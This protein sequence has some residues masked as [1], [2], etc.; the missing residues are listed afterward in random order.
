MIVPEVDPIEYA[1]LPSKGLSTETLANRKELLMGRKINDPN[2]FVKGRREK[3]E[4]RDLLAR[5]LEVAPEA[6]SQEQIDEHCNG[7]NKLIVY[8]ID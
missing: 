7:V 3:R 1:Y 5:Q 6:V 8:M 4:I 2:D